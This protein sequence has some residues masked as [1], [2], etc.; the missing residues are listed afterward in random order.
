MVQSSEGIGVIAGAVEGEAMAIAQVAEGIAQISA[1]VQSN[2][3][4]SE[5]SAA[6]SSELFTQVRV[7][8][9]QTNRFR[10]QG[11]GNGPQRQALP[12]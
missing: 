2:S 11:E 7:L 4:S 12:Y 5:E 9:D 6:V 10:L 1:V 3:A 8:S